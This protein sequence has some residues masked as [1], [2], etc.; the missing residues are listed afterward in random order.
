MPI[1]TGSFVF[2]R[3]FTQVPDGRMAL[4]KIFLMQPVVL[5]VAV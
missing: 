3:A 5:V 2:Q 1:G 4:V